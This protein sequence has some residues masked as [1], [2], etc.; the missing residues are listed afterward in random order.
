MNKKQIGERCPS[1][2]TKDAPCMHETRDTQLAKWTCPRCGRW[3]ADATADGALRSFYSSGIVTDDGPQRNT[4][5]ISNGYMVDNHK[6]WRQTANIARLAALL[7]EQEGPTSCSC[8]IIVPCARCQL[9]SA[10]KSEGYVASI[11]R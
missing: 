3:A 5:A 11:R 1:C 10:L 8:D 6:R 4:T 7:L 2:G 9:L